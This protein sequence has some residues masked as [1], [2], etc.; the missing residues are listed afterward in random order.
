M[1]EKVPK[2]VVTEILIMVHVTVYPRYTLI[3]GSTFELFAFPAVV[4]VNP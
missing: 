3:S 4:T 2:Y 1:D